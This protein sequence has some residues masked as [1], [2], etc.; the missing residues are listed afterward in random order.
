LAGMAGLALA[1]HRLRH[2][3]TLAGAMATAGHALRLSP[4]WTRGQPAER[5]ERWCA[6]SHALPARYATA[7]AEAAALVLVL[8]IVAVYSPLP[9]MLGAVLTAA[10]T[11]TLARHA[12]RS[13]RHARPSQMAAAVFLPPL[14][15]LLPD[16]LGRAAYGQWRRLD[17]AAERSDRT[18]R[19]LAALRESWTVLAPLAALTLS[20]MA[21]V[22]VAAG[23]RL[24]DALDGLAE[25]RRISRHY[26]DIHAAPREDRGHVPGRPPVSLTADALCFGYDG[27]VLRDVS[28][29]VA[30]GEIVAIAG[31]SGCGKSTL[32]R[33]LMGCERPQAG[34]VAMN[35][36]DLA[37][38][39]RPAWRAHAAAIIQDEVL[40]LRALHAQARGNAPVGLADVAARLAQVGLW[41]KVT[42]LP[43]GLAT[44]V[45]TRF[46]SSGQA[47]Q[48]MLARA[49]CR[50]P[51][52]LFLDETLSALDPAARA[53]A[54]AA[55][56]ASGATCVLTSHHGDVLAQADR[57]L[58]L[59]GGRLREQPAHRI[60]G[61][62]PAKI[63]P[64]ELH[65]PFG[66]AGRLYRAAALARIEGPDR[67]DILPEPAPAP[68][69]IL[70]LA[71]AA[72][73]AGL[74]I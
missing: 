33:L 23:N 13:R 39:N 19:R 25:A 47:A 66:P 56:R 69:L 10:V 58:W 60:A 53:L 54:F 61:V 12:A 74:V 48:L 49:L 67:R 35:G 1:H 29:S 24:G 43:M 57:I 15:A 22:A 6:E 55:I 68:R 52:L 70:L 14:L 16:S 30:P 64:G 9:V 63:P 37:T 7:L 40:Y 51:S 65:S 44:L 26:H 2:R 71:L 20:P 21:A 46:L 62:P 11:L 50:R 45:D 34:R 38:A 59:D 8:A 18:H 36:H 73:L 32:M 42:A 41:P 4:W 3:L 72:A 31:P 17:D 5:L 28:L 27:P